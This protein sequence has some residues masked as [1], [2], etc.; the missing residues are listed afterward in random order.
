[1]MARFQSKLIHNPDGGVAGVGAALGETPV[2]A[3]ESITGLTCGPQGGV[4]RL[5][6]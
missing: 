6:L 5:D 2:G 1:M 4:A 3:E